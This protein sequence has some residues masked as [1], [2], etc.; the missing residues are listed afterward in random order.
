MLNIQNILAPIE[1]ESGCSEVARTAVQLALTF[2]ANLHILHVDDPLAGT[3]TL[4]AGSAHTPPHSQDDLR[5]R[6][7]ECVPEEMLASV[8]TTYTVTKGDRVEKIVEYSRDQGIDLIVVGNHLEGPLE[9]LF[10]SSVEEA[11]INKA[12]CHIFAVYLED[13]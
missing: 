1:L 3:P 11:L 10:F 4:V 7:A 8:H 2:K 6:V 5:S 9:R 13:K 12:Q